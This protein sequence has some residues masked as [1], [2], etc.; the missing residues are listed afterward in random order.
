MAAKA[1]TFALRPV[2]QVLPPTLFYS[3]FLG[4]VFLRTKFFVQIFIENVIRTKFGLLLAWS[5]LL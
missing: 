2:E 5:G 4:K 3:L 1:A